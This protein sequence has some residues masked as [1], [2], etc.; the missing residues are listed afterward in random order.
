MRIP[1]NGLAVLFGCLA[2]TLP[3]MAWSDG[4]AV[5]AGEPMIE[6]YTDPALIAFVQ[7]VVETNP[8]VRASRAA[9]EASKALESAAARPLY[10]PEIE[11]DY[12]SAVDKTWSVGIGQ[13]FDWGSKRE[14]RGLVASSERQAIAAQYL[15]T[16]RTVTIELL[17][18]LAR[19]QTGTE[20]D[21]LGTERVQVMRDFTDLAQRRFDAGDLNQVEADLALLAY[22]DA[23]IKKATAATN[24]A[25]AR[26]IVRNLTTNASP[27]QWP[28]IETRLPRIPT[29]TDPQAL[30]LAL[31]E[32]M[33]AQR[34]VDAANA[35][36]EL[37]KREQRP[38]PT[39]SLRGGR[40]DSTNLIGVNLSIPLYVRNR[41]Q[42][43]TRAAAAERDQAQQVMDDL[44][45]RAYARYISASERYEYSR[46]AWQGWEQAGQISLQRQGKLLQRLWEAGELSTT[47]FLVQLRQNLDTRESALELRQTMWR[48][49][50]EWLA[51]SGQVDKW[52]GL[53]NT[54]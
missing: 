14:A 35:L 20:R 41:F 19:Y 15:A 7:S 8:G 54:L 36:L 10:N 52:L 3:V 31:P 32:V 50:F 18:G 24:L 12:E 17:S 13:T 29:V 51:A 37:R 44:M 45:R 53:E 5:P 33:A 26:Q 28:S 23:Q 6:T 34:R 22:T 16:R 46:E 27:D 40:E 1:N 43:E 39:V 48:A 49:W 21:A 42:F 9:L 25:E 2:I 4:D 38:D 30:V 11:A 47:D